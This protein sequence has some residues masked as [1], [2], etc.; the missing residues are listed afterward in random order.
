MSDEKKRNMTTMNYFAETDMPMNR[1]TDRMPLWKYMTMPLMILTFT[2]IVLL[3]STLV[4]RTAFA[5][6]VTLVPDGVVTA[7]TWTGVT[8]GNLSDGAGGAGA[9]D[10]TFAT[11]TGAVS[12]FTLTMSNDAAYTGTTINS[13]T[14]YVRATATG[15][16]GGER[17]TFGTGQPTSSISGATTVGRGAANNYSFAPT[18]VSTD[19]DVDALEIDVATSTL[20]GGEVMDIHEVWVVVNYTPA[21]GLNELNAC[22]SCHAQP[23]VEGASRNVSAGAVVGSHV[24]HGAYTCTICHPNNAV[25]NHRGGLG[26][27]GTEGKIDMLANIQGGSYSLGSTGFL[28]DNEDG[29]GLGTCS[30]VSCH[31]GASS[32]SPQWGSGTSLA[33]DSC[34]GAPP[35]T[36]AHPEHYA[37]KNWGGTDTLGVHCVECHPDNT[38]GHSNVTDSTIIINA[39]L[40]PSGVSP[41]ISCGTAPVL[42]C[43]NGKTTPAF[44]TATPI[45]CTNCHTPGG[46]NTADPQTGLHNMTVAGVQKHDSTLSDGNGGN[47]DGCTECHFNKPTTHT[48]GTFNADTAANTDRFITRTNLTW[49]DNSAGSGTCSGTGL[50]GC[51]SDSGAWSR[52]W[53]SAAN[54]AATASGD[55]RCAVCHGQFGNWR[56]GTSHG[57]TFGTTISTKGQSHN[58]LGGTANGCEDCHSYVT[59]SNHKNNFITINDNGATNIT[60]TAGLAYCAAC[61]SNDGAYSANGSHTFKQSV[62]T[63]QTVSGANDPI[64][65]CTGCH[66]GGNPGTDSAN[67]WPDGSNG[68]AENN[69]GA[70]KHLTHMTRLATKRYGETIAQLL[71]NT[72]N[73]NSD[74]KQKAL[75]DYCHKATTQDTTHRNGTADVFPVGNNKTLW[76]TADG[77]T[78]AAYVAAND[79]CSNVDCHNSKLTTDGTFG[80]YDA[81]TSTCTMCHTVGGAGS[82]PTTGLHNVNAGSTV[83]GKRHDD[84]LK[85]ASGCEAC[86]GMP[87]IAPAS[88]H[89]NG[90]FTVDSNSNTDRGLTG[91]YTDAAANTGTCSGGIAG[92]AGCHDGPGDAGTWMRRWSNTADDG[93]TAPCANC[94]GGVAGSAWT[95]GNDNVV[96]DNNVSHLRNWDGDGSAEVMGNHD[97]ANACNTCHVYPDAPYNSTWG[98]GNHGNDKIDMNSTVGYDEANW[99]CTGACH[100]GASNTGHNLEDSGWG[101]V[102][103]LAGPG[104]SCTNCHDGAGT[105]QFKV[106]PNSSHTDPDGTGGTYT[107]GVGNCEVCHFDSHATRTSGVSTNW[108]ARTMGTDYT[109]DGKIYFKKLAGTETYEAEVCWNCHWGNNMP[110]MGSPVKEFGNTQGAYQTGTLSQRNW[111][112]ATWTSAN[113]SAYK[114]GTIQSIHQAQSSMSVDP[115]KDTSLTATDVGTIGCTSCHDVHKVGNSGYTPTAQPYL[116]GTWTSNP[117]KEDGAPQ[118]TQTFS[119]TRGAVPRG[120][121]AAAYNPIGGWQ[122]E[123]NNATFTNIAYTG[124]SGFGGLCGNC[125]TQVFLEGMAWT[126]HKGAVSGF[127]GNTGVDLYN[128][129]KRGGTTS[130]TRGTMSYNNITTYRNSTWVGGLRNNRN[131]SD[132]V[133]PRDIDSIQS[134]T[135]ITYNFGAVTTINGTAGTAQNNFH[136]FPCAK[137]HSPHASRLPRLMITNCLDVRHNTWDDTMGI[138]QNWTPGTHGADE[139]AYSSTAQNCHRYVNGTDTKAETGSSG[140]NGWNSL[141][142]W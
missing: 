46:G 142:P 130:Y 109:A 139:L 85:P 99:N 23:P 60:E 55:P 35:S 113:F 64:G 89:I 4:A 45:T 66:G 58:S 132:G 97:S 62:F 110:S 131:W 127:T 2:V 63:L 82:N 50:T 112:N 96:G 54:S 121:D 7:G 129:T 135:P 65:S 73:G 111:F 31:G 101:N 41:A 30:D 16:G 93:G 80:W 123:Q 40:S 125:H 43:H 102:N 88:T 106:G 71:T 10:G 47:G 141:T 98:T 83:T 124:A 95:F 25:L 42:G 61:H 94:H 34:H 114:N 79:T 56:A 22:D 140:Q 14:V 28:Q 13:V 49:V 103:P 6:T 68:N 19:A 26:A 76:N 38:L 119:T 32:V 133:A 72:G 137:C 5:D 81:G 120:M 117:F 8:A 29:T 52:L 115:T 92:A 100:A 122:I 21:V 134:N 24:A 69:P 126:G 9:G 104:L 57:E 74:V 86:H 138:P 36:N 136:N 27:N 18:G 17:I 70:N 75:C 67:F 12:T 1:R 11:I 84:T 78:A 87:G 90:T 44:N 20:G 51:H 118:S 39:G 53:S 48:D 105:G 77:G 91:L 128:D 116:R 107:A 37:A 59:L 15:S 33:C 3:L 108:D